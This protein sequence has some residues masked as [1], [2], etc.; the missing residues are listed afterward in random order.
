MSPRAAPRPV[1]AAPASIVSGGE[2]EYGRF[3]TPFGR[4]N[5]LDVARPYHNPVPRFVKNWRLKEWQA[6]QFGDERWFFFAALYNAKVFSMALFQGWDRQ[7]KKGFGF[8]RVLPGSAFRLPESLQGSRVEYRG[9]RAFLAAACDLDEGSVRLT[10]LRAGKESQARFSGSF[11]FAYG[12]R[13]AAPLAVCLPLGLNR[14]MYSTKVLMPAEGEFE[15]GGESF[16]L[17]QPGAM[18]IMDDH[19]GYYPYR[20]RYDW[21]TGFGP[22][23]K[24]RRTGFNLTDNQVRDQER[25]NENCMWINNRIWPLP[26]VRVTRPRGPAG[27][28]IVQDTRGMVDLVFVPEVPNDIRIRLGLVESDYHGPFGSFRGVIKNG[29]GEKLQAERLYGAGEQ[30]Y[31]RS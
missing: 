8:R 2:F 5:M 10:V 15:A 24:G 26:P 29:E 17:A 1:L 13:L 22:D 7:E 11:R 31:L 3:G 9:R 21:V 18:G 6:F 16:R 12:P 4:V 27:E 30:K 23:A 20:M 28:W 19:K 14:A 25:W